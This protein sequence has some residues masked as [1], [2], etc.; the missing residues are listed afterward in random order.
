LIAL[1]ADDTWAAAFE[2]RFSGGD[3]DGHA[4]GN[5]VIIGLADT[6]GDFL[7]ALDE[8]GRVLHAVGRVLPATVEPVVLKAEVAGREVEGQVAVQNSTGIHRVELVPAD[9]HACPEAVAAIASADQVVLAPGSLY[10]SLLPVLCVAELRDA[11]AAAPVRVVQVAN[12][13]Q[14]VPETS[15]MD[16]ADHLQAVLDHGARVD[17]LLWAT[18][19][20]LA[21]DEGRVRALGVD[22]VGARMARVDGLGHDP[23]QLAR[24]LSALL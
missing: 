13:R 22:P 21:V 18:D 20:A 1:A 24:H 16:G 5:L 3:L 15:G 8:A 14:Q 7:G 9:A 2:H 4:L 6:M 10:T 12:L 17:T 19:G 11:T 23:G